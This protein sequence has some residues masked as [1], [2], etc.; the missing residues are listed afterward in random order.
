VFKHNFV[1]QLGLFLS[2]LFLASA[3]AVGEIGDVPAG[4]PGPGPG[5]GYDDINDGIGEAPSD[6][7]PEGPNNPVAPA[8]PGASADVSASDGWV[9]SEASLPAFDALY[10]EFKARPTAANID[11]LLAV[12]AEDINDFAKAAIAVRFAEDGLVDVRDGSVYNSDVS[13]AYDPGAWY[14]VAVSADITT[15]TYDVEIGRCGEPRETLI[16]GASF[17]YDANVSDQL[18]TWAVWSSQAAPLELSTPT[19]MTSGGCA[20]ATCQSLGQECG[21]PSDGCGGSL[22]CGGCEGNETCSSGLCVEA[23]VSVPPPAPSPPPEDGSRPW[24][25]NTGPSDPGAL[26]P[27]GSLTIT[28]DGAVL[29]NLDISGVVKIDADNVTIRNFRINASSHYGLQI[30][31]GA[32][33]VLVEDGEI[34]GANSTNVYVMSGT[35]DVTIR[36]L[37]S[38]DSKSDHVKFEGTN[39]LVESSFFE[40][41]CADGE[42]H[43]DGVQSKNGQGA[44]FRYNNFFLPLPGTPDYPGSPYK[45]NTPFQIED[46]AGGFL[47]DSNWVNGGNYS[48]NCKQSGTMAVINNFIGRSYGYGVKAGDCTQWTNNRWEDTGDLL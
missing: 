24:A 2:I 35:N 14:T 32:N 44:T 34:F 20:P 47:I 37:W 21:R 16:K 5:P 22:A 10:F 28:T 33:N 45:C 38:H 36:R 40:K 12:G 26:T 23:P 39:L 43:C 13:Y 48:F 9:S 15:E 18:R 46:S 17:R 19:W 4:A 31:P 25:H 30:E 27:S 1:G 42:G 11:G 7:V 6:T 3:C 8:C 29:E 41:A